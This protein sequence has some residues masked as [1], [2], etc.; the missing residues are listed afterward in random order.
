MSLAW[1]PRFVYGFEPFITTFDFSLP[2]KWWTGEEGI[3]AG[4][5][6]TTA[7]GTMALNWMGYDFAVA[8]V[9]RFTDDEYFDVMTLFEWMQR[10][11]AKG[12]TFRFDKD[13]VATEYEM[14]LE[15]PDVKS[16]FVPA[17][18]TQDPSVWEQQLTFRSKD[19]TRIHVGVF[20]DPIPPVASAATGV[21]DDS[22]FANWSAVAGASSYELDV[23][24]DPGFL[25]Y[26]PGFEAR[27][28]GLVTTYE[29]T[30][31]NPETT[32]YYRV[33]TVF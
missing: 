31:L 7:S 20:Q 13:R 16:R 30:G 5:E 18:N 33:R 15:A 24:E 22:F 4:N 8:V 1:I 6:V 32:Y 19:G 3:R 10:N 17:R 9:L 25:T 27:D 28:V 12:F 11:R 26:V 2:Q 23:A 21:T 29:V 14:Y